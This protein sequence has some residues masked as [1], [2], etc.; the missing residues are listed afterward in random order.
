MNKFKKSIALVIA[1]TL[2]LACVLLAIPAMAGD[3]EPTNV[4]VGGTAYIN[5]VRPDFPGFW[6][7]AGYIIDG[8]LD[9]I[10]AF[11]E[12]GPNDPCGWHNFSLVPS[13]ETPLVICVSFDGIYD[14]SSLTIY[15]LRWN[16]YAG[17]DFIPH[18]FDIQVSVDNK[19]LDDPNKVWT[20]VRTVTGASSVAA[21]DPTPYT[22]E[23]DV[24]PAADVRLYITSNSNLNNF[25]AIGELEVYGVP[26]DY[27]PETDPETQ[28]EPVV[29]E[30][31]TDPETQPENTDESAAESTDESAAE[32]TD[33][34]VDESADE[35]AA[36][37]TDESVDESTDES[38]D[39]ADSAD[40][41]E[42]AAEETKAA[43]DEGC[44]SLIGSGAA[45]ALV[46]TLAGAAYVARKKD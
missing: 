21:E 17:N 20:T 26:S 35:S 12:A 6:D 8:N 18:D 36:E 5:D 19:E 22:A 24:T 34:S 1:T 14:I 45:I 10:T 44:A 3:E 15:P 37:S 46:V 42:S 30:P 9:Y 25:M 39:V 23:F 40:E 11:T 29:T 16:G 41:S 4:A 13:A 31:E 33:E 32:S 27:V 28:P 43:E 38:A 7:N 2:A